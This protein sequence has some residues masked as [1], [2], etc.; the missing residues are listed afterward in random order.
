MAVNG[1][2][3]NYSYP[4]K[5]NYS[6]DANTQGIKSGETQMVGKNT[7]VSY[8][9]TISDSTSAGLEFMKKMEKE[10][11]GTKFFVGT[12]SYGQT[13]GNST[14]TNFVINPKFLSKLGTDEEAQKQFEEDIKYLH[15]FAQNQRK[16]A[17]ANGHE[18]ISQGWFCDENGNWG[19]W[20][21]SKSTNKTSVLQEMSDKAE[22]I[23]KEKLAEKKEKKLKEEKKA[24]KELKEHFGDRFKGMKNISLDKPEIQ[25]KAKENKIVFNDPIMDACSQYGTLISINEN[26]VPQWEIN[27]GDVSKFDQAVEEG[28]RK[29]GGRDNYNF[30]M[31]LTQNP[32]F[33]GLSYSAE[34]IRNRLHSAGIQKGFFQVTVGEHTA[35]QFLS[36]G[37]NA[38]AVYSK[39]YYDDQ[40][41]NYVKSGGICRDYEPGDVFKIDGEEYTVNA[42]RKLDVP[43][44]V[45][46]WNI[47]WPQK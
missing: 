4:V 35:T 36:E 28:L 21:Y 34:D 46:I 13:Y 25:V 29:F 2:G 44:G 3:N 12:V 17:A 27:P 19:G 7:G 23:R 30:W 38:A 9:K 42:D 18:V 15:N 14:D 8:E 11:S 39:A 16:Q 24:E 40:Y 6:T 31:R 47:E 10:N 33:M 32:T 1:I 41:Y 45:D 26:G 5:S 43:Y 37:K 20:C 22:K